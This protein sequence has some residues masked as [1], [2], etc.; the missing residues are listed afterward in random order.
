MADVRRSL[1]I[2]DNCHEKANALGSAD[3]GHA[4]AVVSVRAGRN[5]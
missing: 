2:P 1:S 3:D 5:I 4:V